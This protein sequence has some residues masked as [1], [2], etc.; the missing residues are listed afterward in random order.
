MVILSEAEQ[1]TF[2]LLVETREDWELRKSGEC[3]KSSCVLEAL[4]VQAVFASTLFDSDFFK[5]SSE[6]PLGHVVN[7]NLLPEETVVVE[8]CG[9]S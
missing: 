6:D 5:T 1:C 2:F 8:S 7:E 3:A 4:A 9:E